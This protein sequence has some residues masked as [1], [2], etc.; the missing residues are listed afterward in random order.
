MTSSL[1][2]G[3]VDLETSGLVTHRH[4]ILQVG[5]VVDDVALTGP[6]DTAAHVVDRWSALVR[7]RWPWQRV[8]PRHVHGISRRDLRGAPPLREVLGEIARRLDGAIFT[9]HNA[10][11][12]GG[13]L[14]RA[15]RREGV[16]LELGPRLCTLR[17]SRR[18]DPDRSDSHRLGD[19][20]ARY[21]VAL[22][23]PHDALDD[24]L[25]TAGVL[26]HLL[27]AHGVTDAS[28]LAPFYDRSSVATV[29]PSPARSEPA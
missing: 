5:L 8:G 14:E 16:P 15:A 6:P 17:M 3:V 27:R 10:A 23:G 4:R 22:D 12:D 7:L 29:A 20:C 1:R 9:A 11:F 18:L 24:A 26:P 2:F 21:H 25:A 13:F 19:V 28:Q